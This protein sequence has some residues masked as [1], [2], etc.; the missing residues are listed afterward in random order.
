MKTDKIQ[1][2]DMKYTIVIPF[3]NE[4]ESVKDVVEE[5]LTVLEPV[6]EEPWEC[7]CVEDGSTDGTLKALEDLAQKNPDRLRLL[8]F[9]E[10]RGQGA[11]LYQGIRAARGRYIG[12]M[13]GDGQ[14]HPA[15][16]P[17]LFEGLKNADLVCGIRVDRKDNYSRRFMSRLA[18]SVRRRVLRDG[19]HDSGCAIK[20]LRREVIDS[21]LPLRTL[22]SFIPACAAAAGFRIWETPCQHRPRNCGLSKYGFRTFAILPFLDMLGIYWYRK[23][24]SLRPEDFKSK[25]RV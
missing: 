25:E 21:L 9:P 10:N 2:D 17:K 23:R 3:Y 22:Y 5:T 24:C 8:V 6:L 13:D 12:L 16:F 7:L 4:E 14:N 18:N 20:A 11:A 19:V 1:P 15:D